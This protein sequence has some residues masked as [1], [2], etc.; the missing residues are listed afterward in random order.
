MKRREVERRFL[1]AG[2][3]LLRHGANHDVWISPSGV[4]EWL[5]RH[6]QIKDVLAIS[7]FKKHGI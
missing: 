1:N 5:P 2:W 6:P 4:R 7:L 3:H